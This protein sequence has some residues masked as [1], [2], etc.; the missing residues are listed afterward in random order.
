M[1]KYDAI[2]I[3]VFD[4]KTEISLINAYNK[5]KLIYYS[6]LGLSIPAHTWITK[7]KITKNNIDNFIIFKQDYTEISN[8]ETI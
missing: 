8:P 2:K 3:N 1:K 6:A 7:F 5:E 4:E